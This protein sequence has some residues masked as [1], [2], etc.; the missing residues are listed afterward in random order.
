MD[1]ADARQSVAELE[2]VADHCREIEIG[3][4]HRPQT[5]D[6]FDGRHGGHGISTAIRGLFVRLRESNV[7]DAAAVSDATES[8]S[9]RRHPD[10]ID[11]R[12]VL[13]D[14]GVRWS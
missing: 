9:A 14:G 8:L 6:L 4:C 3:R 13:R 12:D 11:S 10:V 7:A 5:Y 1:E 2:Q